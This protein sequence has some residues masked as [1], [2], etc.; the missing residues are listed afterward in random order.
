MPYFLLYNLH[1]HQQF[2]AGLISRCADEL[3]HLFAIGG[4]GGMEKTAVRLAHV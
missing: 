3:V 2:W 4:D 1:N